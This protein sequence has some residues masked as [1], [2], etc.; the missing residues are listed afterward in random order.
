MRYRIH[1]LLY[2]TATV[3]SAAQYSRLAFTIFAFPN[4]VGVPNVTI[5]MVFDAQ[6]YNYDRTEDR[7]A[8]M[9]IFSPN[10]RFPNAMGVHMLVREEKTN[11][12]GSRYSS[13]KD[14]L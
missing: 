13:A 10:L 5:E 14:I 3:G 8:L 12:C 11:V 4:N 7:A 1:S 9:G 2:Y 6:P